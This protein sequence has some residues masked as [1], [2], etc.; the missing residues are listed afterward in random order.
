MIAAGIAL[1]TVPELIAAPR[2]GL[3]QPSQVRRSP[4]RTWIQL[5]CVWMP[6]PLGVDDDE[7]ERHVG[8][9][10][11][12]ERAVGLDRRVAEDLL[13]LE[14]GLADRLAAAHRVRRRR[15]GADRAHV[16]RRGAAVGGV[17]RVLHAHQV[18]DLG[19]RVH[20]VERRP[21]GDADAA[22]GGRS[23]AASMFSPI[24]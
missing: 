15:D 16:A 19:A 5:R 14:L 24:G 3:W 18:G 12:L 11:Q 10:D 4:G 8:R 17:G 2:R 21:L 1:T 22:A 20:R 7:A 6:R 13:L 9:H 23:T